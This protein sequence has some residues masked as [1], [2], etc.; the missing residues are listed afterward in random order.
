MQIRITCRRDRI[1]IGQSFSR[2]SA[3]AVR[4]SSAERH[5]E[6]YRQK[7]WRPRLAGQ[8]DQLVE[9]H[10]ELDQRMQEEDRR[11]HGHVWRHQRHWQRTAPAAIIASTVPGQGESKFVHELGLH[12]ERIT[13]HCFIHCSIHCSLVLFIVLSIVPF[14][15]PFVVPSIVLLFLP[16]FCCSN[17]YSVVLSIILLLHPLFCCSIHCSINYSSHYSVHYSI[18]YSIAP[19]I[20]PFF[21]P[22]FHHSIHCS[23]HR[24]TLSRWPTSSWAR[25]TTF[26]CFSST[27]RW[28]CVNGE[29]PPGLSL[30]PSRALPFLRCLRPPRKASN[31]WRFCRW[32]T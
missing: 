29:E 1:L 3:P 32:L 30:P 28:S 2:P 6:A 17:H 23:I 16:L 22:S 25:E 12:W 13:D 10:D 9:R 19:L 7:E 18:H 5:F 27:T 20:V 15:V 31:I 4:R 26:P 8:G 11:S 24:W 14:I 21:H